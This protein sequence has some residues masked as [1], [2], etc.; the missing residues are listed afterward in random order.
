MPVSTSSPPPTSSIRRAL[1][2][3]VEQ[4][5]GAYVREQVPEWAVREADQIE[6]VDSSPEQFRH[7]M[8]HGN[9][10]PAAKVPPALT[11]FFRTDNLPALRELALRFVAD[12]TEED[13]HHLRHYQAQRPWETT[14]RI[15]V[16]IT[17]ATGTKMLL[18]RAARI[19]ARVKGELD[20]VHVTGNAS[21]A[22]GDRMGIEASRE[23]AA[24][25]GAHGHESPG[26]DP[27]RAITAFAREHQII[28]IVIDSGQRSRRQEL[29][30]GGSIARRILRE[31]G[32]VSIDVHVSPVG[33]C[34]PAKGTSPVP[35]TSRDVSGGFRVQVTVRNA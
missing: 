24:S 25:L 7:R 13:L 28:E 4:M 20:I 18:R 12:E 16:A 3:T 15:R 14:G 23:L 26:D 22:R 27:A 10:Y 32:A 9:L 5:T 33:H 30:G 29:M 6:P 8:L 31:A 11:H 35:A 34:R 1:S 17:A 21:T 2:D 19:T